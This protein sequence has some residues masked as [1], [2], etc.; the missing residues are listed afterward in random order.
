LICADLNRLVNAKV[1]QA[2]ELSLSHATGPASTFLVLDAAA[3]TCLTRKIL[4]RP[5]VVAPALE[6]ESVLFIGTQ[7][8]ILYTFMYSPA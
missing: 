8:S 4:L 2:A 6:R 7:F 5:P 3:V 1:I